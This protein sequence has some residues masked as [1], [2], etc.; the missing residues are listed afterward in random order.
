MSDMAA[1]QTT[2]AA[3]AIVFCSKT[4]PAI[5][6]QLNITIL[7]SCTTRY[8]CCNTTNCNVPITNFNNGASSISISFTLLALALL[9]SLS[10]S[11]F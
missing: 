5:L 8:S 2:L 6:S 3:Y 10:S 7:G 11:F 1:C 4:L 9:V